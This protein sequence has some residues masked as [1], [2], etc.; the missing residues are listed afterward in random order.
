MVDNLVYFLDGKTYINLTNACTNRCT[1]CVRDIKED[2]VGAKLWL[3]ND[4]VKASDV[5]EQLE[6]IRENIGKE[7]VFCGYGEPLLRLDTLKEVSRYIKDN[8]SDIK[9][10]INTNGHAS[11]VFNKD[12]VSE[13]VGLIDSVSISLNAEN[14]EKYN[15]IA[16]P[17][18]EDAYLY[19]QNFARRCVE[20]GID[21]TLSIVSGYPQCDVDVEKC[22]KI[23][24]SIGAKFR[25][26]EWIEK[27]Y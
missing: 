21:T 14:E 19:M 15:K 18:I 5:I 3:E 24:A 2:V 4:S 11:A 12:V 7:V 16:R 13:L 9:I 26:R 8:F 1:F 17:G 27:G 25:N 23:C 22:E 6:K 10:R 20:V